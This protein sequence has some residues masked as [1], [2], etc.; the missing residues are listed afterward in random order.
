MPGGEK[1]KFLS[2]WVA[3]ARYF[4]LRCRRAGD[5]TLRAL[6]A[7]L[8]FGIISGV[9]G[10]I[11]ACAI[12][13]YTGGRPEG[14]NLALYSA[15]LALAAA[16]GT[17]SLALSA[18]FL[19]YFLAAPSR[20][21]WDDQEKIAE[22]ESQLDRQL[23]LN[24]KVPY[25]HAVRPPGFHGLRFGRGGLVVF[26]RDIGFTNRSRTNR[27]SLDLTLLV[28]LHSASGEGGYLTVREE[29]GY[30][31]EPPT[32]CLFSPVRIG[33][34]DTEPGDMC[35]LIPPLTMDNC[36]GEEALDLSHCR[37]NIVD[38]VSGKGMEKDI[39]REAWDAEGAANRL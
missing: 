4:G 13:Y 36:G 12:Y 30:W 18:Y 34:Q 7:R 26:L 19:F 25:V 31:D 14:M 20:I 27:V 8:V 10:V 33:P 16:L 6:G 22:L 11:V 35:F 1:S 21:Y 28:A 39:S 23:D 24:V 3:A 32:D 29:R 2:H 9:C 15:L 17:L 37:L 38:R 5:D